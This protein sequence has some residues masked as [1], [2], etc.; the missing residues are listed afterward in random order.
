[1]TALL[2]PGALALA[3]VLAV[4]ACDLSGPPDPT[5][6]QVP[7]EGQRNVDWF[8]GALPNHSGRWGEA[9]DYT[10]GLKTIDFNITTDFLIRDFRA[11]MDGVDALAAAPGEVIEVADGEL[12]TRLSYELGADGNRVTLQ[13]HD[14]LQSVYRNL[15]NGSIT[16]TEGQ[17]VDAGQVLGQAGSSG[18]SNWPRVGFEARASDGE[19]FDPWAGDCSPGESY[20]AAQPD[21]PDEFVVVDFGTTDQRPSVPYVAGRP[22]DVTSFQ[23]GQAV[24]F[25]SHVINRPAGDLTV[26]ITTPA[27]TMDSTATFDAPEPANTIFNGFVALPPGAP[28]GTWAVSYTMN[29]D[30]YAYMEFEVAEAPASAHHDPAPHAAPDTDATTGLS[31]EYLILP[32]DDERER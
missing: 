12:D 18:E 31:N 28:T 5:L 21:Y 7:V 32:E 15:K 1:M 30:T 19:P 10:C 13:H 8:Y 9:E 23:I 20:W 3:V 11:M 14:G 16:V 22:P 17:S 4:A 6:F 27:G 2:R 25:W 29:G 26:A 24:G